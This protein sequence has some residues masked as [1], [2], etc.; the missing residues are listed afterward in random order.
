MKQHT[1]FLVLSDTHDRWPY[2]VSDPAPHADVFLH[3]GDLTQVGGLPSFKRAIENIKSVDA[4]LKLVIAGNHDLELDEKWVR[5]NAEG[6]EELEESRRCVDLFKGLKA[7]GIYYLEEGT[8]RFTLVSGKSFTIY[9][10]PFT[11]EFNGYAFAYG[12][13]DRFNNGCEPIPVQAD[14]VMT[15]GPPLILEDPSYRLDVKKQGMHCGCEKL[16]RAI[17][18][19]KPRLHCFGHIH[20]GRGAARVTWGSENAMPRIE[21]LGSRSSLRVR[22]LDATCDQETLLVNAAMNEGLGKGWL[23]EMDLDC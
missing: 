22:D 1:S 5:E 14:I 19:V 13:E 18:R 20:E 15:H 3:C 21:A 7:Y 2:S 12:A 6:K 8:H 23:V 16:A 17:E 9:V 4:E 11:P 10:S